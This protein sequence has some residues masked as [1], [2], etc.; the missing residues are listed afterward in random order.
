MVLESK[1][2]S[3]FEDRLIYSVSRLIWLKD[4]KNVKDV[5]SCLV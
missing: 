2:H 3:N 4:L 5:K 1:L